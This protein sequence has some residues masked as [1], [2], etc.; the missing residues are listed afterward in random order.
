MKKLTTK[1]VKFTTWAGMIGAL[2]FVLIF[3]IEG[4]MR[5]GY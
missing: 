1:Q 5:P 3:T 4:W 2:L